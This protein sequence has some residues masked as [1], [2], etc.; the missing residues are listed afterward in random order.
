MKYF[1]KSVRDDIEKYLGSG[2]HWLRHVNKHGKEHVITEWISDW[3][4]DKENIKEFALKFSRD[5]NIVESDCWLNLKPEDGLNG[6][7]LSES[8]KNKI[9]NTLKLKIIN[10]EEHRKNREI[11]NVKRMRTVNSKEWRETV[12]HKSFEKQSESIKRTMNTQEWKETRGASRSIKMSKLQNDPVWKETIG[13]QT[14]L[15]QSQSVSRTINDEEW[16]KKH[17]KNC[18]VCNKY[19]D[20]GNFSRW[21]GDKCRKLPVIG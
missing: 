10:D 5:N 6:G 14:R 7:S 21:H 9:S 13:K 20:P 16:K 12:G 2:K 17:F 1:G 4:Y 3:F 15:K 8:G 11:G 19:C 18:P